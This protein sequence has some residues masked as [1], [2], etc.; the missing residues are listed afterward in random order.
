MF[1]PSSRSANAFAMSRE[2]EVAGCRK[3][4]CLLERFGIQV[5]HLDSEHVIIA[6]NVGGN[7]TVLP[8]V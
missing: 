1:I 5:E 7:P 6:V 2:R 4:A 3:R 8:N